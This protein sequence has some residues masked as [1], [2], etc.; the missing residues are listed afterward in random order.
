MDIT[1]VAVIAVSLLA[2]SI[3]IGIFR[4]K[5]PGFGR[6]TASLLV[7]TFVIAVAALFAAGGKLEGH[8]L[9]NIL[10]AAAGFS[11]GLIT[12]KVDGA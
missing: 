12:A 3:I 2:I 6:Y 10:F 1:L 8:Q 4:T 5:K 7:L 9:A 11:G